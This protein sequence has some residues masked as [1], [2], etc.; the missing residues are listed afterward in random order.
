MTHTPIYQSETFEITVQVGNYFIALIH[1][2]CLTDLPVFSFPDRLLLLA[3]MAKFLLAALVMLLLSIL[4]SPVQPQEV[5]NFLRCT[6]A[7]YTEGSLYKSNLESLFQYLKPLPS[8]TTRGYYKIGSWG[9]DGSDAVYGL[10]Q[11]RGDVSQLDCASCFN[12][13]VEE[14]LFRCQGRREAAIL[15]D[16]CILRYNST[17]FFG[18]INVGEMKISYISN[19][20]S[21]PDLFE[22]HLGEV[23]ILTIGLASQDNSR[24]A[25]GIKNFSDTTVIYGQ[26]ECTR[27][28]SNQNCLQCLGFLFQNHMPGRLAGQVHAASCTMR[29]AAE[30]FIALPSLPPALPPI[31]PIGPPSPTAPASPNAPPPAIPPPPATPGLGPSPDRPSK[32]LSYPPSLCGL[33]LRY[34]PE[35]QF[36]YSILISFN[37]IFT[38]D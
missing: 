17:R 23:L 35:L 11:C 10:V 30:P 7:N 1:D 12:R 28:L 16:L 15:F 29:Y 20:S 32:S 21:E 13:S 9:I 8:T 5:P 38:I 34:F 25:I 19:K 14:A 24:F 26:A 36:H 3:S 22:Q 33:D 18:T 2:A 6:G 37:Y 27:D 4:L 31:I